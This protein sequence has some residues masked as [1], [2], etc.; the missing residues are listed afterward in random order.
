MR[1]KA[2][3]LIHCFNTI[4][5][6]HHLIHEYQFIILLPAQLD[7]LLTTGGCGNMQTIIFKDSGNNLEVDQIVIYNQYIGVPDL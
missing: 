2:A 5:S 1:G 3:N 6:G 4:H 7:S